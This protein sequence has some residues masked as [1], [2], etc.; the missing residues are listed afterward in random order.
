MPFKVG[1]PNATN[2]RQHL[3]WAMYARIADISCYLRSPKKCPPPPTLLNRPALPSNL[4]W[5]ITRDWLSCQSMIEAVASGNLGHLDQIL[6]SYPGHRFGF[7]EYQFQLRD[8]IHESKR[9]FLP[10]TANVAPRAIVVSAVELMSKR[11]P[12]PIPEPGLFLRLELVYWDSSQT[13][14][15]M[16]VVLP[17]S[18]GKRA[19]SEQVFS[20]VLIDTVT[21]SW[22]L[23][24]HHPGWYRAYGL[25]QDL[26]KGYLGL[27]L[28]R[29]KRL[30]RTSHRQQALLGRAAVGRLPSAQEGECSTSAL[31]TT[32]PAPLATPLEPSS[33][34]LS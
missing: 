21:G 19:L 28:Y 22:G 20:T 31:S 30:A 7:E 13:S 32:L 26:W 34:P 2:R 23:E 17:R 6:L 15:R 1:D 10:T 14:I 3:G 11:I 29:T 25:D 24:E 18:G 12:V 4:I 33:G 8:I 16:R 27:G 9:V 5:P